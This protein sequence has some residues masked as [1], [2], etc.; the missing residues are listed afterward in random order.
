MKNIAHKPKTALSK[1]KENN[2]YDI[3]FSL[4]K[5][6][7]MEK[8]FLPLSAYICVWK[9]NRKILF[10]ICSNIDCES[11]S[12]RRKQAC[13]FIKVFIIL[14]CAVLLG[15]VTTTLYR[16]IASLQISHLEIILLPEVF[17]YRYAVFYKIF[18]ITR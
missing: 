17:P 13:I 16:E 8:N 9:E 5:F 15:V 18:E 12:L 1:I 4:I 10:S 7:Y 3:Y 11:V 14:D 2:K 6:I